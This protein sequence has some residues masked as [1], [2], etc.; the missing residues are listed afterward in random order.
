[1]LTQ[2][3]YCF[4]DALRNG[5]TGKAAA[6][7]AGYSE[8]TAAQAAWKLAKA[9]D[10]Q[11]ALAECPGRMERAAVADRECWR[12]AYQ[13]VLVVD[14]L[15]EKALRGNVRAMLTLMTMWRRSEKR[16]QRHSDTTNP[17]SHVRL[18]SLR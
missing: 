6:M 11:A 4:V 13:K 3:R 18:G 16:Q 7:H 1:M 17:I 12:R 5:M 15:H 10:I 8:R 9:Q 14:R 2:R